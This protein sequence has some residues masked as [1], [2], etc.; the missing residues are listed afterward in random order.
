MDYY[1]NNDGRNHLSHYG[2][3]GQ[4]WHRRRFQN[5]DDSLT[6]EGRKR[7][8]PLPDYVRY[9]RIAEENRKRNPYKKLLKN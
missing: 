2:I 6:P 3:H 7:Y 1:A 5:L 8:P 9:A 4:K